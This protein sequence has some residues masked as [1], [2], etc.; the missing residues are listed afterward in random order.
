MSE[1]LFDSSTEAVSTFRIC[2]NCGAVFHI[3][4]GDSP[5]NYCPNCGQK[6]GGKNEEPNRQNERAE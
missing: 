6:K 1:W 3:M 2:D 5:F 4:S